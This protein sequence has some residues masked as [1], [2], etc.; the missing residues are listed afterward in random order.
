MLQFQKQVDIKFLHDWVMKH[1]VT[2]LIHNPLEVTPH[3]QG[4]RC[5]I[6]S[7]QRGK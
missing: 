3:H 1:G 2:F 4:T 5:F 7:T 6:Q